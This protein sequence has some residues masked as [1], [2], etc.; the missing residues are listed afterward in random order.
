MCVCHNVW[1]DLADVVV[2]KI[3]EVRVVVACVRHAPVLRDV[4]AVV[5][6]VE[7][8]V[9]EAIAALL[10]FGGAAPDVARHWCLINLRP[11]SV[12]GPVT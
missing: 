7:I 10:V 6:R 1:L 4:I 8:G 5:A 3:I 12:D 2:I 11:E 9:I